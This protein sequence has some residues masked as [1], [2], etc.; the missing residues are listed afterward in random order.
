MLAGEIFEKTDKGRS[1]MEIK[2]EALSMRER[3]VLILANGERTAEII[4]EQSLFG[5]IIEILENLE[6]SGYI[7]RVQSALNPSEPFG[8]EIEP[9]Y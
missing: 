8:A 6:Q 9:S 2:S 1:E 4:K 7:G 5:N 3:R